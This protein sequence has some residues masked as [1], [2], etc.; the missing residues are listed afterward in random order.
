MSYSKNL[1]SLMVSAAVALIVVTNFCMLYLLHQPG[2]TATELVGAIWPMTIP[3]TIAI[4]LVMSA[5]YQSLQEVLSQLEHKEREAAE[6]ARH[7]PLTG[8]ANKRLLEERINTAISKRLRSQEDFAVLMIDLDN[9]KRVN[10]VLGHQAGDEVLRLAAERLKT[11][12]RAGDTVARFGGD[13]FLILAS[14]TRRVEVEQLCRRIVAQMEKPYDLAGREARLPVSV[15]VAH[16]TNCFDSA[17]EYIRAADIALYAAKSNGKNCFCFFTDDLDA[18]LQRRD[19]LES[20]LRKS[21]STG[22]DIL[23]HYQPQIGSSGLVV[24]VECL[25]RWDHPRLGPI[26]A[27]ESISVAEESRQIDALGDFVLKQAAAFARRYPSLSVAVN[28]SPAQ[29]H[30]DGG[31]AKRLRRL[32]YNAGIEPS[33]IELEI[34]EQLFMGHNEGCGTEV[35]ELR[36]AGFRLALDDFGTGYSSLSYLRR[37]KVDRLKLDR[38]FSCDTEAEG[39]IALIRAAVTLAHAIGL[40]VVAEGIETEGQEAMALEAGC[41]VLQGNRFAPAMSFEKMEIY[42]GTQGRAA[43]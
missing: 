11:L 6:L 15:G 3:T 20:D 19:L 7:D 39:N 1:L 41:D 10:D 22:D 2:E 31:L 23:V 29:F 18:S 28:I 12:V 38:S 21:L 9:F 17:E 4:V 40:E 26:S 36:K 37:F 5:L 43:A 32:V 25:F 13:E 16:S 24:G 8:L 14:A 30:Q 34:T 35:E 33:Q 42:L 27:S